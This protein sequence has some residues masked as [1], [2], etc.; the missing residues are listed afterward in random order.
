MEG[1]K[2]H[3]CATVPTPGKYEKLYT[4]STKTNI[5]NPSSPNTLFFKSEQAILQV[6]TSFLDLKDNYPD[7]KDNFLDLTDNF[8]T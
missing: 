5:F 1:W 2:T 4:S 8:R 6:R 3:V 7:L